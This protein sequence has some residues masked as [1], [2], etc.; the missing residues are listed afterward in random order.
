[1]RAPGLA[2]EVRGIGLRNKDED[3]NPYI[4]ISRV[5]MITA[6]PQKT[7]IALNE[8]AGPGLPVFD[9][10]GAFLGLA[11]SSFAQ[12]FLEFNGSNGGQPVFLINVE[13]SSV[14]PFAEEV[15]PYFSRIPKAP[16][17]RPIA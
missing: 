3:F 10:D 5:G 7:A 11:L 13:E 8:V 6:L 14:F 2:Q 17:S 16:D 12:S 1:P 4:M 15:L 9:L